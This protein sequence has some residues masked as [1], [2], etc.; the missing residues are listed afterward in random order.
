[1][2]ALKTSA[3]SLAD[4]PIDQPSL[5]AATKNPPQVKRL[6][7]LAVPITRAL[8]FDNAS[9]RIRVQPAARK[10]RSSSLA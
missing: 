2:P 1:M 3:T 5:D 10:S 8:S 4:S 7:Q 9:N 6:N